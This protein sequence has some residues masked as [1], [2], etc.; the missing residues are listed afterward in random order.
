MGENYL[1][2]GVC[3]S[4]EALNL[5]KSRLRNLKSI[6]QEIERGNRRSV[7]DIVKM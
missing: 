7:K 1:R 2:F 5:A 3:K 6:L 4:T